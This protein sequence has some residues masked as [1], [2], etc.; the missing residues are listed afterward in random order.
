MLANKRLWFWVGLALFAIPE[1]LWSPIG[2]TILPFIQRCNECEPFRSNFLTDNESFSTLV[3]ILQ[4]LGALIM[5]TA[6]TNDSST[7]V[8][9]TKVF[10]AVLFIVVVLAAVS[11]VAFRSIGF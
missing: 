1:L 6:F 11:T 4:S 5:G 8:S 3:L 7:V 2:N 9:I 10:F